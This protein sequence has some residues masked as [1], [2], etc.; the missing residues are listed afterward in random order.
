ML[1]FDASHKSM[2]VGTAVL[3]KLDYFLLLFIVN[4][5][6]MQLHPK[7][8][9]LTIEKYFCDVNIDRIPPNTCR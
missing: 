8:L 2:A 5:K 3:T 6:A 7:K 4:S 9:E 1:K